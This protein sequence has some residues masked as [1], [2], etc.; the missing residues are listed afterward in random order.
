[1]VGRSSCWSLGFVRS[2]AHI[3]ESGLADGLFSL[4][5]V[6]DMFV[7]GHEEITG[8][9]PGLAYINTCQKNSLV[10]LLPNPKDIPIEKIFRTFHWGREFMYISFIDDSFPVSKKYVFHFTAERNL[11]TFCSLM[12]IFLCCRPLKKKFMFHWGKEFMYISS[13]ANPVPVL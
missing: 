12:I 8:G 6:S 7:W 13:I 9:T 3:Y 1:M 4:W 5:T 10:L 11:C 2:D